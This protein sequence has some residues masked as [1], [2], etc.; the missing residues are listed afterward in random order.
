MAKSPLS[1]KLAKFESSASASDEKF[2][3]VTTRWLRTKSVSFG[4]E[5]RKEYQA[6]SLRHQTSVSCCNY[7]ITHQSPFL[8]YC[9]CR[10]LQ[11]IWFKEIVSS[12]H[13]AQPQNQTKKM[14]LSFGIDFIK[15]HVSTRLPLLPIL[16]KVA[17]RT[18]AKSQ[19][20][21]PQLEL[22]SPQ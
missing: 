19:P 6:S 3:R 18:F 13:I 9:Q 10:R 4:L 12:P 5:P 20:V 2:P 16:T 17:R 14:S 22:K 15:S 1:S 7:V 8:C 11:R 21:F